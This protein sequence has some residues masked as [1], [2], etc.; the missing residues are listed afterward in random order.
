[1][2]NIVRRGEQEYKKL[3]LAAQAGKNRDYK[4]ALK[5][6]QE[7]ISG[8][9][10]P[11][12]AWLLLGRTLHSLGEY[13]RALAAFNDYIKQKPRSGQAFLFMGR[14]YLAAGMPHKAVL[15]L[16][17]AYELQPNV[18]AMALLA[19]AYLKS[20][21]SREAVDM[22]KAAV[23]SAAET[24][25]ANKEYRRIYRA[26][27]NALLVRGVW[28]CRINDYDLGSQMLYFVLDNSDGKMDS[29]FLRLELG[30]A[31]RE[32]GR[33]EEALSHYSR[34][35]DFAPD[36]R[37]IRWSRVSI[38][39]ALGKNNEAR[40]DIEKIRAKEPGIPELP[41]NSSLVDIFMIRSFLEAGEWRSAAELCRNNLKYKEH[42]YDSAIIHALFAEALRNLRDFS[43]AH[44][45][46][47]RAQEEKPNEL[48][49]WYADMLVSWEGKDWKSLKKALRVAESLGGE[50]DLI[51]R[52]AALLE[53][54]NSRDDRK[55]LT[56]LQNAIRSLGPEP[57][58][59]Y[60][61]AGTYLR[62]GFVKEARN[63]FKKTVFFK[64]RHEEA[65]LG[66]IATLEILAEEG[67]EGA[68]DELGKLYNSYLKR[69]PDNFNIRRE[70]AL[71]LIK[72]FEYGEAAAELE[73]LL[74]R[75]PSNPSLR[76]VLAYAYRKTGRYR[77][78]AVFLKGLL[79]EKPDS[80]ELLIEY[81]GCLE[82]A[83]G[84]RYA[85]TVLEK[86]REIFEDSPE[87]LMALGILSFRTKK[88]EAAVGCE[89]E[90]AA[91]DRKDPRP[92]E[93]MAVKKKKNGDIILANYH[94]QEAKKRKNAK[95]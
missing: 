46:L 83:G 21:H 65:W 51:K 71:F 10:V 48:E 64:D 84:G 91:L 77:E 45:H 20:K 44:N 27:L 53:A 93:W 38:L 7:L 63:W 43:T 75:E 58:L 6:L 49:F 31:C 30:R 80:L 66:E 78:A 81:S 13:S 1:M 56:L 3:A 16:K 60:A 42:Q 37:R 61:L 19:M 24:G 59:M 9:F 39:M 74:L 5:I 11:P 82:R 12:E 28:L 14:T 47:I 50:P 68:T 69:W 25:M 22:F 54:Q 15:S 87:L 41:W 67:S 36:D 57:E 86:A 90:A 79:R 72:V 26:Y 18:Q 76:R 52:F 29:P 92:Y 94:T 23:E 85:L 40:E 95:K 2:A 17:R 70:R 34:A 73:K 62:M 88:T 55:T 8:S 35:L 4:Q 33:M 89:K 32:T